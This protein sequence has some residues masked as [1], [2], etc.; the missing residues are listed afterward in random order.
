MPPNS[1]TGTGA[2]PRT[3]VAAGLLCAA[4]GF[5]VLGIVLGP[6]AVVCGRLAMGR[7]LRGARPVLPLIAVVLGAIDTLIAL[8]WLTGAHWDGGGMM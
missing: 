4:A 3:L 2:S 8:V 6:A 5:F 1:R 7:T